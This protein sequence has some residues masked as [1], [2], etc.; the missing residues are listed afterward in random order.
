MKYQMAAKELHNIEEWMAFQVKPS[1]VVVD[2]DAKE[3]AELL[4][5]EGY[6]M[7]DRTIKAAISVKK[8]RDFSRLCRI[9]LE[10]IDKLEKR[11]YEIAKQAFLPDSRFFDRTN[12]SDDEKRGSICAFVDEMKSVYICRFMGEIAGFLEVLPDVENKNQAF[13]RLAAVDEKYRVAGVAASLYAGAVEKCREKGIKKI[14]GRISSRNMS[15]M[16]LYAS[17]GAAFSQPL[18]VYVRR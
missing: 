4:R 16:N 1:K 6:F 12:T 5:N 3:I 15:V 9:P 18:D 13:I 2:S 10:R 11:I 7:V 17:M 14:W 8:D